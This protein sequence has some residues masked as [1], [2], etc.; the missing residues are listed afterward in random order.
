MNRLLFGAV[1]LAAAVMACTARAELS[2]LPAGFDPHVQRVAY[3]PLNVVRVVGSPT[4]STQIIFKASEEITQ[5]AIGNADAW[6][7][8]PAGN[9]LFIKPIGITPSTNMQVVTK[10]PEGASRS[11]QFRLVAS[12]RGESGAS[13]TVY[14]VRF[15]YPADEE[16]ERAARAAEQSTSALQKTATARLTQAWAESPRNWRYVAKG[17][18]A[19]EPREVS[20]NG[21]QTAFRFPGAMRI[22]TIYAAAPDG[23]ETIVPYTM[24]G[25]EAVVQT[26]GRSFTLRDGQEVLLVV[27]HG[28]DPV[29]R[30]P[31]TGTGSPDIIR[32]VKGVAP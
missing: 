7:A 5:V 18:T 2:P 14:A 15:T 16:K 25:D 12:R 10:R 17:S 32:T 21:R 8:Q 26:T 1:V 30:N 13:A 6:L 20:D 23:S 4:N 19:I 29:G 27:N 28:L 22:P 31:G 9:L 3:N 24:V 11:Y